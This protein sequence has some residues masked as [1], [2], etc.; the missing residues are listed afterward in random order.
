[1]TASPNGHL[2]VEERLAAWERSSPGRVVRINGAT[3]TAYDPPVLAFADTQEQL[4]DILDIPTTVERTLVDQTQPCAECCATP[5]EDWPPRLC[6]KCSEFVFC[7]CGRY[8]RSSS[9]VGQTVYWCQRCFAES[10]HS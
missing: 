10:G 8:S 1:M 7:S 2:S 5:G 6:N 4:A 3:P 9:D